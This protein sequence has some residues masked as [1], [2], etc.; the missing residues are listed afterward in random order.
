M[1]KKNR[2]KGL[3]QSPPAGGGPTLAH[4]QAVV[5]FRGLCRQADSQGSQA[6]PSRKLTAASVL[7]VIRSR[8]ELTRTFI[9][10]ADRGRKRPSLKR[11][12]VWELC[13]GRVSPGRPHQTLQGAWLLWTWQ[14]LGG[15]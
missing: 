1:R 6:A 3:V 11:C 14:C 5:V 13:G 12:A 8:A 7:L 10:R 15:L 2:N 9:V 4:L